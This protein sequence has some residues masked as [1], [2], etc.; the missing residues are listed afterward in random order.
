MS[1]L[2]VRRDD[3]ATFELA[4]EALPDPG[5]LGE[6]EALLAVERFALTAN[7]VTYAV[8]GEMLG[9]ANLFPAADEWSHVPAWGHVRVIASRAEGVE[10]GA[11]F[12]GLVPMG[13]GFVARPAAHAAGF[14]DAAPHRADLSP[15]YNQYVALDGDDADEALL[16]LRPLFMTSVVLDLVLAESGFD[17]VDAVVL[18]SASSKTAYGLAH[19]LR[20]RPV[21]TIGLTSP[22]RVGWVEELG[23][24]D[25]VVGYDALDAIDTRGGAI[26]MDF[27]GDGDRVRVLHGVLGDAL[28]RSMII[29]M[30]DWEAPRGDSD[31]M[32]GVQP[33]FFFAPDEIME[34]AAAAQDA[35]AA[36]WPGFAGV[37]ERVMRIEH[38]QGGEPLA[39]LWGQL[40][41]GEADPGAGYIVV[42]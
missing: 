40:V 22:S 28:R 26:L 17:D 32:P 29:G 38:V 15:I 19:L 37:A 10:E 7:N 6:G 14:G 25:E 5:A 36:A 12:S 24:Y 41:A 11:R 21:R 30:T 9:Y 1:Q 13:S 8:L 27:A 3:P 35:F 20:D 2:R 23:L 4:E 31:P 42:V 39:K 33:S 16:L 34:R 18:T